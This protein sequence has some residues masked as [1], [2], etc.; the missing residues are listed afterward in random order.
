PPVSLGRGRSRPAHR[1]IPIGEASPNDEGN[2]LTVT[3]HSFLDA[4]GAEILVVYRPARCSEHGQLPATQPLDHGGDVTP[5][6][7]VKH[8]VHPITIGPAEIADD[9]PVQKQP[10][11]V[12]GGGV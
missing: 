12:L 3:L 2:H 8:L 7:V 11:A 5:G 9:L 10:T 1:P 6:P 4:I